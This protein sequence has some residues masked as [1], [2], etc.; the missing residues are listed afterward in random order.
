MTR[1]AAKQQEP[2]LAELAAAWLEWKNTAKPSANTIRARRSD[3]ISIGRLLTDEPIEVDSYVEP[4]DAVLS[5]LAV[6]DLGRDGLVSAFSAF[7]STHSPASIRRTRSTWNGFC[8][9]LMLYREVLD[10]NPISFVEAPSSERWVPK[11]ISE[12]ELGRIVEA[13]QH[14][15]P[16]A[17]NP[18]PEFEQALCAVFIGAGLRISEVTTLEVRG[19]VRSKSETPRLRVKGKGGKVRAVPFPAEFLVVVD[20]YLDS[21]REKFGRFKTTA[22]LFVRPSSQPLTTKAVEYLVQGWFRRAGVVPPSGALAHSL[23]HTYATLIIEQGGSVPELQ[24]LLGHSDM[25]TTQAYIEVAGSGVEGAA[26]VNPAR[27]M[28]AHQEPD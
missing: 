1:L 21:R 27:G 28:V 11:P 24:R 10:R 23:R 14:P 5:R 8:E 18:W 26:M 12:V 16:T 19:I 13:A 25:S 20:R 7:A 4:L 17:R 22:P 9:W 3:I 15:S 2:N 6:K